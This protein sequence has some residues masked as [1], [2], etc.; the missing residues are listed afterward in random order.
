MQISGL[1]DQTLEANELATT[2]E[3]AA[4]SYRQQLNEAQE[5]VTELETQLGSRPQAPARATKVRPV[6]SLLPAP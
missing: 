2:H 5:R 6:I 4:Q 1:Q 3:E